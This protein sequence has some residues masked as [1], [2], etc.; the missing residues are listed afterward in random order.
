MP[1][2]H[3]LYCG[4]DLHD[5][6]KDYSPKS[7]R[8]IL[9]TDI[10]EL[11]SK[12]VFQLHSCSKCGLL[13]AFDELYSLV[14]TNQQESL[15]SADSSNEPADEEEIIDKAWNLMRNKSWNQAMRVLSQL[16]SPF[17]F[18]AVILIYRSICQIAPLLETP[19]AAAVLD[20]RYEIFECFINNIRKIPYYLPD[21]EDQSYVLLKRIFEALQ[22][23]SSISIDYNLRQE[24][25]EAEDLSHYKRTAVLG[26]FADLLESLQD[27]SYGDA[28]LEMAVHLWHSCIK[29][30]IDG[31]MILRVHL[32]EKVHKQI[33]TKIKQLNALIKKRSP[34]FNAQAPVTLRFKYAK[35]ALIGIVTIIVYLLFEDYELVLFFLPSSSIFSKILRPF[36]D[37]LWMVSTFGTGNYF[38]GFL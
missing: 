4:G 18:P 12:N 35:G 3:C 32:P 25:L 14:M 10:D 38:I 36:F 34:D 7:F 23:F 1:K 6:K 5:I 13:F 21:N 16:R 22:L 26:Q 37:T 28:Y 2:Q 33:E 19:A 11:S 30:A 8:D 27:T 29:P 17:Q 20:R 15:Q 24:A 31:N 9:F